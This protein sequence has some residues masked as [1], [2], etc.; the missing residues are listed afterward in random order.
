MKIFIYLFGILPLFMCSF[1]F[2][3]ESSDPDTFWDTPRGTYEQRRELYLD[4]C[5]K[6][7]E[8]KERIGIFTQICR[9]LAG[10]PPE[11]ELVQDAI[12]KIRSNW[13]CNDF[14]MN[15]LLRLAYMEKEESTLSPGLTQRMEECILDFKYWWT[16]ARRDTT[17]RCYHT[18]NHQALYHTAE[19]LAGQLY[20]DCRFS[21]GLTG[22]EHIAHAEHLLE[23][24]LDFRFRFG[25]SEWNSTYYEVDILVLVNLFDY[26]ENP[27]LKE[28]ARMVLDLLMY[29]LALG[30]FHG[31]LATTSGRAYTHSLITG[32]HAMSPTLKLVFGEGQYIPDA[33]M[34]NT[35]LAGSS[36]RCPQ[37][38]LDIAVDYTTPM[39]NRQ[40]TSI[41][42]EDAPLYGLSW[43]SEED[44]HL[45]WGIQEFIHPKAIRMS[46]QI[47]ET[48][49]TYPYKNY[50]H[51]IG[52]YEEQVSEHGRIINSRLD[53][54]ALS[55]ANFETY[56]TNDYMLSCAFDYRPGAIAYQQHIWQASLGNHATVFTTHPGHKRIG[57]SPDYWG[58][59]AVLPRAVQHKNVVVCIY[60]SLA[61]EGMDLTHARFPRKAFEEVIEQ[62]GWIFGRKGNGYV[63]L[64]S[65]QPV[66]WQSDPEGNVHDVVAAG[67]QNIWVCETGSAEEWGTFEQFVQAISSSSVSCKDLNVNYISPSIGDIHFG[68]DTPF[69]LN[70]KEMPLKT[71]YRY[72]NP[73][74]R[75]PFNS[76][77]IEIKRGN[78][79]LNLN[80]VTGT[81]ITK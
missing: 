73:Y 44:T 42:V 34:G 62:N 57:G 35:A 11:E 61:N 26:A 22:Q 47:S 37:V 27:V 64:Y 39:V 81:R 2:P 52:L 10:L 7:G 79:R 41:E 20:K 72:D 71:D 60:N 53:R 16:D 67:R 63:A 54:F 68:W 4:Y 6:Y 17:Y 18:E 45:F 15:G 40:K 1:S 25:F 59:S 31:I 48:Y 24:W 49:H 14:S 56:R 43:D 23:R 74:S 13:D 58:G 28:Q 21:S 65:Q 78:Y 51:Y 5:V 36:Y 38:I 12:D 19:L 32:T 9:L 8:K 66:E 75:T 3:K 69:L 80:F 33:I 29:D 55:E 70:G 30:N 46:K 76:K 77:E 50:D